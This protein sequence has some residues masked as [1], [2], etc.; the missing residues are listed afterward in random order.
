[1]KNKRAHNFASIF[2]WTKKL[3]D[4]IPS[5]NIEGEYGCYGHFRLHM[6]EDS[7]IIE[8]IG[9][10][11]F[12]GH[13]VRIKN[14]LVLVDDTLHNTIKAFINENHNIVLEECK[15]DCDCLFSKIT[16]IDYP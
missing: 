1:M 5:S 6:K 15:I 3:K 14:S 8:I 4:S 10:K 16:S 9:Y 12:A 11:I 2:D 13:Y 7:F